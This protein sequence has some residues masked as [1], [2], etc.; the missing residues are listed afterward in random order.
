MARLLERRQPVRRYFHELAIGDEAS[1]EAVMTPELVEQF[2]TVSGD[3]NP[4]HMEDRWAAATPFQSRITHGLLLTGLFSQLVG[5]HLPGLHSVYAGQEV[6]FLKP[7]PLGARVTVHGRITQLVASTRMVI[8]RTWITNGQSDI[9]VD[10]EAKVMM[11]E[12]ITESPREPAAMS[13][14]ELGHEVIVVTGASR[15]IG[16]AT[17][18]LLARHGAAVVVN[19]RQ[20]QVKAQALV[21]EI[22]QAGGRAAAIA[23]DVT[24][25]E[26]VAELF[27]SANER[28]GTV[29]GLV[30]NAS[31]D[32]APR[33]FAEHSWAEFQRDL[34]VIVRGGFLCIQAALPGFKAAGHGAI[35]NIV[36]TYAIATPPDKLSRYVTA[37]AAL[38]GLTRSLAVELGPQK[39]RVNAVAPGLTET[40]LAAH[41]PARIRDL[42]AFQTPL[43]RNGQPSDVA[44]VIRF[45]LSPE[46][47]FINGA[48]IPVCGGHVM[49]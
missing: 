9:V 1:F 26:A 14:N 15:G 30:N 31:A 20:Q 11:Q 6:R 10:G 37:K 7:V 36:S 29:T 12:P 33:P 25:P 8:L 27:A 4:L 5:M 48:V 44:G 47:A 40:D 16:A 32:V 23:A 43:K 21:E 17:A 39:I 3:W 46:A 22:Q 28:F 42:A 2:A 41:V 34:D 49:V 19:Y 13:T 24:Q 45:L 35:V 18:A 38:L